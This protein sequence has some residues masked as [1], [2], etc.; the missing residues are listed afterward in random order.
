MKENIVTLEE[1]ADFYKNFLLNR[2]KK[3]T[4]KE[5]LIYKDYIEA[6][7]VFAKIEELEKEI[8]ERDA[9][10]KDMKII[11]KALVKKMEQDERV[12][13][14]MAKAWKQDDIRSI[15]EIIDHFRKKCE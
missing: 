11:E 9:M 1:K 3:M 13:D 15:E 10:I 12:I 6:Y 2:K 4:N 5:M 8:E 14:E 7:E